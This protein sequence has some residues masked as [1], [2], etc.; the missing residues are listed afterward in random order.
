MM[1][2]CRSNKKVE[3]LLAVLTS[4]AAA[5]AKENTNKHSSSLVDNAT[6]TE[7]T[8]K[9]KRRPE[10]HFKLRFTLLLLQQ[11]PLLQNRETSFF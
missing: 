3:H 9:K 10:S 5:A 6:A 2:D 1:A 4:A 11:M 7:D 8:H